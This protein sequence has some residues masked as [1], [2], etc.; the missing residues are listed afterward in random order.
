MR[1]T[2]LLTSKNLDMKRQA[3]FT[4]QPYT[5]KT[6]TFD[7]TKPKYQRQNASLALGGP[8]LKYHSVAFNTDATTTGTIVD[9]STLAAGDTALLRD[10]NKINVKSFELRIAVEK[11]DIAPNATLRFLL[12]RDKQANIAAI[13]NITGYVLDAITPQSLRAI[14]FLS[15]FDIL[16]DK[17]MVL[18]QTNSTAGCLQ[19][20]FIKKYIKVRFDGITTFTDG[21]SAV[22]ASNS[23]SLI[24]F[25]DITAGATDINILG[26]CRMRFIG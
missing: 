4:Q 18:N 2:C 13:P 6:K 14:G 21:T 9:L 24:Y 22:P 19:K 1:S 25:S 23:Y 3:S 11:E 16:M 8:E 10:G 17:T 5:K 26:Q 7:N 20:A 15:R 12:V